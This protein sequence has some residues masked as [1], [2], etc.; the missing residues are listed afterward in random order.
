M[1][2]IVSKVNKVF[3][4]RASLTSYIIW[5]WHQLTEGCTNDSILPTYTHSYMN[6]EIS[7]SWYFID[8]DGSKNCY[9]YETNWT[10]DGME[11]LDHNENK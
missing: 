3:K 9:Y 7:F 6:K 1:E 4:G 10:H 2:I 5:E 11:R 8:A